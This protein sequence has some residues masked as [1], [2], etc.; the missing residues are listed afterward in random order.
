[1]RLFSSSPCSSNFR[2]YAILHQCRNYSPHDL[3]QYL[4]SINEQIQVYE[5][6][7]CHSQTTVAD[8]QLFLQRIEY[9][10]RHYYFLQVD[11][12]SS[13]LQEVE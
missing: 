9:F 7:H 4:Y 3:I 12:L 13:K 11:L 2:S 8:V 6:L 10:P 5:I 1:M